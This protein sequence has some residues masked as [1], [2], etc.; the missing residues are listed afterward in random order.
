M[1]MILTGDMVDAQ[2]ARDYGACTLHEWLLR[3]GGMW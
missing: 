2:E 3:V 1:D